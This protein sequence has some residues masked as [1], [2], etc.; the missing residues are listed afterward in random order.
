MAASLLITGISVYFLEWKERGWC[1][2]CQAWY[3][4]VYVLCMWIPSVICGDKRKKVGE[5]LH[6]TGGGSEVSPL[7]HDMIVTCQHILLN[8]SWASWNSPFFLPQRASKEEC[9][10]HISLINWKK[11]L[12]L[13]N[14]LRI[15][16]FKEY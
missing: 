15:S 6:Y 14:D 3:L 7:C 1:S 12:F 5:L 8:S 2:N 16:Y 10:G 11:K 9:Q 13:N 4:L